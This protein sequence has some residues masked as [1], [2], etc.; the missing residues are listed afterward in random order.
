M[1]PAGDI[2]STKI[3][4]LILAALL[5]AAQS[6]E[7]KMW[8]AW[9]PQSVG[10][11]NTEAGWLAG[12]V[13]E[14]GLVPFEMEPMEEINLSRVAAGDYD[15]QL[16]AMFENLRGRG[17]SGRE[18]GILF[19]APEPNNRGD[20]PKQY[21]AVFNHIGK[22]FKSY[23]PDGRPAPLLDTS[24]QVSPGDYQY[25]PLLPYLEGIDTTIIDTVGIQGI[26]WLSPEGAAGSELD[27][28]HILDHTVAIEAAKY[29]GVR[30]VVVNVGVPVSRWEKGE[31]IANLGFEDW[32]RT[33]NGL[34][35]QAI[36][37]KE[38]LSVDGAA[39]NYFGEDKSKTGEGLDFSIKGQKDPRFCQ[40]FLDFVLKANE[41]GI[42]ITVFE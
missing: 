8:F 27:A 37:I 15:P 2:M 26:A 29:L 28:Q 7:S 10:E 32:N 6:T 3:F 11:A 1:Q 12:N 42:I 21:V 34:L 9:M 25:V 40:A 41:H 18:L 20:P 4:V 5:L 24:T 17:I 16:K 36:M 35:D 14:Q 38:D 22:L 13:S 39:L 33:L 31:K 19:I 30:N 23:F